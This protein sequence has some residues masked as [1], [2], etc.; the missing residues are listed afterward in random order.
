MSFAH[1]MKIAVLGAHPECAYPT[2]WVN[3]LDVCGA[4]ATDTVLGLARQA[5]YRGTDRDQAC[6]AL[7]QHAV[8]VAE[9][10]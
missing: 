5:G 4:L 9:S 8:V 2:V 1:F 6:D 7:I 3:V 10:K